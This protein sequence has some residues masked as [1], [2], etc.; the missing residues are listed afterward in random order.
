MC[1]SSSTNLNEIHYTCQW[2]L[3]CHRNSANMTSIRTMAMK[4]LSEKTTNMDEYI[5]SY[6]PS[7]V[8]LSRIH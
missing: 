7:T 6:L 3:S 4:D 1:S 2:S 8:N 5:S